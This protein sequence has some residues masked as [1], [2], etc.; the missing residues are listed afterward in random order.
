M[1]SADA[2]ALGLA[3]LHEAYPTREIT[4]ETGNAWS[5][6]FA[7][8]GDREFREGCLR[9][10]R[11]RGRKFFPS[12]GE[13]MAAIR[14]PVSIDT[15]RLLEH[16]ASIG[17]HTPQAGWL[18]PRAE[19]VRNRF[20]DAI[21][22]AYAFAG[23]GRLYSSNETGRDIARREFAEHLRDVPHDQ[24][25]SL[26]PWRVGAQL[27]LAEVVPP[28]ALPAPA[29]PKRIPARVDATPI[30]SIIGSWKEGLTPPDA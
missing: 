1:A 8:V 3:L 4:D 25:R 6:V 19:A 12:S 17:I 16:I 23:A 29:Q 13:L 15:E 21:A 11:E 14:P 18:P 28:T 26:E 22:S 7:D 5:I 20:G 30:G 9:L 24:Q 2:I 10:T 27:E